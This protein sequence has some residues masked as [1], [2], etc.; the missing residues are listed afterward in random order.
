MGWCRLVFGSRGGL[1]DQSRGPGRH[2]RSWRLVAAVEAV[3]SRGAHIFLI[4]LTFLD[5]NRCLVPRRLQT[6]RMIAKRRTTTSVIPRRISDAAIQKCRPDF[7]PRR[8]LQELVF[9][10]GSAPLKDR[11]PRLLGP[12]GT[13]FLG[14]Q[15]QRSTWPLC[16]DSPKPAQNTTSGILRPRTPVRFA[17]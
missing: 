15:P 13:P 11:H 17:S 8:A 5:L 2:L 1:Q 10:M 3:P 16:P 7:T 12:S 9:I 14:L 4:P 6:R